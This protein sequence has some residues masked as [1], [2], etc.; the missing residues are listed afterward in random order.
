MRGSGRAD[1]RVEAIIGA[2]AGAGAGAGLGAGA[3][4]GAGA[5]ASSLRIGCGG[6]AAGGRTQQ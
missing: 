5:Y 1:V 6:P 3:G 4:A 2:G